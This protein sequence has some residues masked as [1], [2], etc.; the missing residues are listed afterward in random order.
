MSGHSFGEYV[1]QRRE[2]LGKTLRGFA[3]ELNIAPAY[4]SDIEKG[5]RPAPRRH[6]QKFIKH[7]ALEGSEIDVF[8]DLVGSEGRGGYPDLNEYVAKTPLARAALRRARDV[9]LSD[10]QWRRIIDS[11]G[12][13]K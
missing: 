11:M 3:A 8:Y 7:L 9:S 4:L 13:L 2:S 10:E 12:E 1:R 6:L 5:Y